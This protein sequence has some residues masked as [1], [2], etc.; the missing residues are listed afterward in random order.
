MYVLTIHRRKNTQER[1]LI[2]LTLGTKLAQLP[3][4]IRSGTPTR[5]YNPKP[6]NVHWA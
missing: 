6:L 3:K 5:L 1:G 2:Y 4:L